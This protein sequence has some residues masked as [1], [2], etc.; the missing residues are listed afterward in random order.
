MATLIAMGLSCVALW[1]TWK[2]QQILIDSHKKGIEGIGAQITNDVFLYDE[3]MPIQKS[4]Q[5]ALTNRAS[6][7][8][9]L[10]VQEPDG[11]LV[12]AAPNQADIAWKHLNSPKNMAA[13][14]N[15]ALPPRIFRV[16]GR[17]FVACNS[18]LRVGD[19]FDGNLFIAQDITDDQRRF[20]SVVRIQLATTISAIIVLTLS[21]A[22]YL[23]RTLRPLHEIC[24]IS[25]QISAEDLEQAQ[26]TI[27]QAPTEIQQ[28]ADTF[29]MM[30]HRLSIT[31]K[32][33]QQSNE[34]QRQ[35]VSN[36]SH[37]LR[38]PLTVVKGYIQ[39]TLRR[40]ENLSAVQREALDIA[41]TEA[42]YTVQVLQDLLDLARADDGCIP[43]RMNH[44]ILNDLVEKAAQNVHQLTNRPIHVEAETD[45]ISAYVDETRLQ[46][47]LTNLIDNAVKYSDPPEPVIVRLSQSDESAFIEI[48]D[49]GPGIAPELQDRIFER[50]YRVDEARTRSG[51]TG[52]GLSIV[53]TF[54]EGMNGQ[55][56][57]Q[58]DVDKGS[59]FT[60]ELPLMPK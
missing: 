10:W 57:I 55:V 40:G 34:R 2:V 3:M 60:V 12:A 31:W 29:N 41:S 49:R 56:S 26:F 32:K 58:S 7:T 1:T 53:K 33:E 20:E 52:L 27:H 47:V 14:F 44:I 17:D 50:F 8:L 37:E 28:L 38:T 36:V 35:F 23:N 54:V 39:S 16:R 19:K 5:K 51:G 25:K 59:I 43:Y 46:Q 45:L 9:L 22:Y 48:C 15:D 24:R 30:L 6:R 18:P 21:V 11:T 42:E 13:I 4:V